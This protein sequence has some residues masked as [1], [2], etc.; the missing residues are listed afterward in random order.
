MGFGEPDDKTRER[1]RRTRR[2]EAVAMGVL[3]LLPVVPY[4]TFLLRWGVPRFGLLGDLAG[5]EHATLHVWS[6]DTLVGATSRFDFAHPGPLFFYVAAP[7]ASAF[8]LASTG[9]FMAA[10]LVNAAAAATAVSC[11]RLFARRPHAISTL[12]VVLGWFM[13]F[14]NVA[15]SP[16]SPLVVGLP[17]LAFLV[18][19]A[20]FARGKTA[21]IHPAVVFGAFVTQTWAPA[22]STVVACGV[23]GSVAFVIGARRRGPI[24]PNKH[25][26][27][28]GDRWHLA[29]A[30]ALLVLLFLPP[31]VD[32]MTSAVG[33]LTRLWR[34]FVHRQAPLAPIGVATQQWVTATS[35][36]PERIISRGL[37]GDGLVPIVA[38]PDP[39]G[40]GVTGTSLAIAIVHVSA[41]A[42]AGVLA[43]WRR[44]VASLSLLAVG[45]IADAVAV[46]SIQAIVGESRHYLVFWATAASCVA[47]SGVLSTTFSVMAASASRAKRLGGVIASLLVVL[48]LAAAVTT[49]SLQRW[50]LAHH[51]VA[52]GSQPA[53]RSDVAAVQAAL[54]ERLARDGTTPVV[55]LEG[56]WDVATAVI[57]ELERDRVDVRISEKDRWGF[58]GGRGGRG[59]EKPLHVWFATPAMPLPIASCLELVAKSGDISVYGGAKDVSS[60]SSR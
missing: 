48:G 13:A 15:A 21:A 38:R 27:S 7:F 19:M 47:W 40:A 58:A 53:L 2:V 20:L 35:W 4:V 25:W 50:W 11:S 45:A 32:Q 54:R 14:G 57:L 6:G 55:H 12:V 1:A 23:A 56:A 46:S 34:F 49:T 29:I 22:A 8:S 33:N 43:A 9:I 37:I 16:W 44:D 26:L 18:T 3:A 59:L 51:P 60:C 42:V 41:T 10:C 17:L 31:L 30:S 28:R 5:I 52:P 36:L 39:M 24:P